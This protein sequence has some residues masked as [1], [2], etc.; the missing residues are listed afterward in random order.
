MVAYPMFKT[1]HYDGDRFDDFR[2]YAVLTD[3]T[4][5]QIEPGDVGMSYWIFRQNVVGGLLNDRVE[6]LAP[7]IDRHCDQSKGAMARLEVS[8]IGVAISAHVRLPVS[9]HKS[10]RR[11]M[12]LANRDGHGGRVA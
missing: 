7:I 6:K 10:S 1:A 9:S 5:L 11:W 3:D 12:W 8:D 4:K 2:V